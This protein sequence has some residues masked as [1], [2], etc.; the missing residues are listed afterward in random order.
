[1][2]GFTNVF[3]GSP[4]QPSEVAYNQIIL[5]SN[6][7]LTWP[8]SFVDTTSVVARIMSVFSTAAGLT[9]TLPSAEQVSVGADFLI[10]NNGAM[11]F[12]LL[13]NDGTFLLTVTPGIAWYV[14]LDANVTIPGIW[15]A[16]QFGAGTSTAVASAL[17]GNG[18]V[19]I[20][21]LL[22]TNFPSKNIPANYISVLADRAYLLVW[23]GG[24]GT[25]TL[26][27]PS[28]GANQG[29]YLAVNNEGTGE[30][31]IQTSDGSTID[32]MATFVLNTKN[33]SYFIDTQNGW[34]TLGFGFGSLNN[35]TVLPALNIAAGGI[36]NLSSAQAKFN[37]MQFTGNLAQNAILTYP[38]QAGIWEVFNNTTGVFS[39]SAQVVGSASSVIIPQGGNYIIY[40]DGTTMY[41]VGAPAAPG[42]PIGVGSGGTGNTTFTPYS[43]ITGGT[44]SAGALQN[45]AGTGTAGYVL[46]SN[47]AA[48]LPTWQ[49]SGPGIVPNGGTGVNTFTPYALIAGGTTSTSSLQNVTPIGTAG[50]ILTSNGAGALPSW[51][52]SGAGGGGGVQ[53]FQIFTAGTA[54]LYLKPNNVT[55]ILVECLGGG[56]G[57][58]GMICTVPSGSGAGAGGG[59]GY[60]RQ[61]IPGAAATYLYTVGAG[62]AGGAAGTNPGANGVNTT[63]STLTAN[64]GVGGAGGTPSTNAGVSG[65]GGAGG[66]SSGAAVLVT[67]QAGTAGVII[68]SITISGEGGSSQ[69]GAGGAEQ[70]ATAAFPRAVNG[71]SAAANSGGGGGGASG[72]GVNGSSAG[73]NGGSGLIIVWEFA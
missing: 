57:G 1:M 29:F 5:S 68:N 56:G 65:I 34:N 41:I 47:G 32:G 22:A 3:G 21:G 31:T 58:G 61:Y 12:N 19:A 37:I 35:V 4:I 17:A 36:I 20:S 38:A 11:N 18:L 66:A 15:T 46:T 51:Q 14:W 2:T 55:S 72:V 70:Y 30:V 40:S 25:I 6:L 62:G 26:P 43:V 67:G 49:T 71:I 54:V 10:Y 45:V 39:V 24:A 64:G 33:S 13:L 23:T 16:I 73:G 8:T 59:G 53:S 60:C 7:T 50:Q 42:G 69:Y 48:M 44:T 27:A 28:A 63:F 52:N 9:I